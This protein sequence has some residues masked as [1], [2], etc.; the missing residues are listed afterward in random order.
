MRES[1]ATS[2]R[3]LTVVGAGP[4]G[5]AIA[6][7]HKILAGQ[8][9]IEVPELC[10]LDPKGAAAHWTGKHGYTDGRL[11]LGTP[12]EKDVGFPY[13]SSGYGGELDAA[14][15]A[16]MLRY[17]WATFH[18]RAD[19]H[20]F[21]EWIDR[22]KPNPRHEHW[23]EYL[24]WVGDEVGLEVR[25]EEL[26]RI[27]VADGRWQLRFASGGTL[28]TDGL[29]LTSPGPPKDKI[30]IE[31]NSAEGQSPM[32]LNGETFW[33][34]ENRELIRTLSRRSDPVEA[35]VIGSGETAATIIVQLV[36]DLPR[37]SSIDV[38]SADG[39]IYTRGESFD[40]NRH[41][42]DPREWVGIDREARETFVKRTDR[43][44]FSGTNKQVLNIAEGVRTIAGTVKRISAD[45]ASEDLEVELDC[46]DTPQYE[47]VVD[48]TGF[49]GGWFLDLFDDGAMELLK[50]ALGPAAANGHLP[51]TIERIEALLPDS[52]DAN[53]AVEGL[54]PP[55]HLPMFAALRQG[56]G[57]PNLSC[58]GL[59]SDRILQ[60]HCGRSYEENRADDADT[61][62]VPS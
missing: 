5:V 33:L 47:L 52:I 40:E 46:G 2:S 11:P 49:R 38:I 58:L 39:I 54:D 3:H 48:A 57:F 30:E 26:A 17:S 1:A 8:P 41:Y 42:S 13:S 14:V 34:Q 43:G 23:A 27:G 19:G 59:T 37:D 12:P 45:E 4:K 60:R 53:L 25:H 35:C 61:L 31:A 55:L 24:G 62:A 9:K 36:R 7:K 56:P 28:A 51:L 32:L 29:V 22:G 21:A 18:V 6:A 20:S 15:D 16:E 44:V 10:V 50:A